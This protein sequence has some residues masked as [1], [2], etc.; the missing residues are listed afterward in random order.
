MNINELEINNIR[1]IPY[2]L[3]KPEGRNLVIWGLNGSGKSAVVDAIDFLLTGRVSRLMGEGT[4]EIS[5]N[6]HGPH[7]DHKAEDAN[8]RAIITLPQTKTPVEIRRC[9]QSPSEVKIDCEPQLKDYVQFVLWNAVRGQH[10]LTRREILKY[11]HAE[12]RNRAESIQSIL[13]LSEIEDIRRALVRVKGQVTVEHQTSQ[14]AVASAERAVCA[15]TGQ[16]A[17]SEEA[18]LEFLNANRVVLGGTQLSE[19]NSTTIQ[20]QL[21]KPADYTGTL[22]INTDLLERALQSIVSS[23]SDKTKE[24]LGQKDSALRRLLAEVRSDPTSSKIVRRFQLAEMGID[25][26]DDSGSCPL[27][28]TPWEPGKLATYLQDKMSKDGDLAKRSRTVNQLSNEIWNQIHS[29]A[30]SARLIVA[31]LET[32]DVHDEKS[33]LKSWL[34]RLDSLLNLLSTALENYPDEE[35][36]STYVRRMAAPDNIGRILEDIRTLIRD[37]APKVTPELNAW[38]ALTRL[39]ENLKAL[40]KAKA[41][42]EKSRLF[43]KRANGLH[44]SFIDTRDSVLRRLYDDVRDRFVELYRQLHRVDEGQFSATIEPAGAGLTFGVDFYRRGH[45]P[46][47]ALHSEGHQDSMG[48]CLYLALAERLNTGLIDLVILDDVV[49]SVD[50]EH[51]RQMCSLLAT[52]FPNKQFIITTHDRTW[53]NQLKGEGIVRSKELV[54]FHNWSIEA[55]PQVSYDMVVWDQIAES[56]GRGDVPTAAGQLRRGLECFFCEVCSSLGA[57][58][59]YNASHRWVLGDWCPS[60]MSE[61]R[62]LIKKAK[63]AANSWDDHSSMDRLAER[64]K[65]SSAIFAQSQAE[66]WAVNA[67]AHYNN[68]ANFVVGDFLPVVSSFKDLCNLFICHKC[69][70]M[71]RV[72]SANDEIVNVCCVCGNEH[73]SL[74]KKQNR[75]PTD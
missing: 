27:C 23:L 21:R 59:K 73:W 31:A 28:D 38:D 72:T 22:D 70:S 24:Q 34:K 62:A 55:G 18:I 3:L 41:A 51:R 5:L 14:G 39:G 58:V 19:V 33:I 65:I 40:E 60:A 75:Q 8:V 71:L 74:R 6:K 9:I 29:A 54:E 45:H 69:E 50:V 63:D 48:I 2:L 68:W 56:L 7:I 37:K 12:P 57:S 35:F 64:E 66:Q 36:T 17:Y 4:G 15:T 32:M 25:L 30:E 67:N 46:P 26:I 16:S 11:I 1:G 10:V 42:L 44:D 52:S 43:L 13:N 47:H 20:Q 49:M 53:A 61:Y